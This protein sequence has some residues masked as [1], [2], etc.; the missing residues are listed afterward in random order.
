MMSACIF[1]LLAIVTLAESAQPPAGQPQTQQFSINDIIGNEGG[2]AN[3]VPAATPFQQGAVQTGPALLTPPTAAPAALALQPGLGGGNAT[4]MQGMNVMTSLLKGLTGAGA[5]GGQPM[6]GPSPFG[7]QAAPLNGASLGGE[8]QAV[9]S[10]LIEA[11]MHSANLAGNEKVCLTQNVGALTGGIMGVVMDVVT[12]I[13][14]L[15]EGKGT[16]DQRHS[17][18][19]VQAGMD[20]AMKLT[21]LVASSTSLVK[22]CVQGDAL[23]FL[24]KTAKHLVNG[25]YLEHNFIVN[26]V[27]IA[28]KLADAVVSF[29]HH[30][31]HKF[32]ADIGTALRK[33]LLS[34]NTVGSTIPEGVPDEVI[35]QKAT[36]GLMKGFFVQGSAIEITDSVHP[37]VDIVINLHQ[38]IADNS[39][40]FKELWLASWDLIAQIS[41]NA[42]QHNLGAMFQNQGGKQPKWAGELMIAMMQFP[43]AL[44]R[45]GVAA[46]MQNMFMEAIK[47]LNDVNI[48]FKMPPANNYQGQDSTERMAKAVEAW[49]NWD[50]EDFGYELGTFFRELVMLAFPQQYSVDESGR[51]RRNLDSKEAMAVAQR[52][53]SISSSVV[54][55]GGAAA[56]VLLALAVVRTRRTS[57]TTYMQTEQLT[58]VEDGSTDLLVE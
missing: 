6:G 34:K 14:A 24:N 26:G 46:D 4:G 5:M 20:A 16:V 11:F 22:G 21:S 48:K 35:I 10:G 19:V 43:M 40:F 9:V 23:L 45:C 53:A 50:F 57:P 8:S 55:V 42:E 58:D 41:V 31:F 47:T 28:G 15:V 27:D 54:I 38:C 36:D 13:K 1:P 56:S 49:S 3:T 44:S 2:G 37:D 51:L 18:G 29:E 39:A 12:A 7:A 17:G 30:D 32:G 33:I 52:S 25:S